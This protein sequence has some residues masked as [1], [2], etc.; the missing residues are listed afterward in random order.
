MILARDILIFDGWFRY[1]QEHLLAH[2]DTL[3][4][5]EKENLLNEIKVIVVYQQSPDPEPA[6]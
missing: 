6:F 4:E 2:W 5:G 3:A 1:G